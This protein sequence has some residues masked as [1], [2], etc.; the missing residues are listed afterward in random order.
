MNI[1]ISRKLIIGVFVSLYTNLPISR[2][3]FLPTYSS[4]VIHYSGTTG[5][6]LSIFLR[7]PPCMNIKKVVKYLHYDYKTRLIK[8]VRNKNLN[9]KTSTTLICMFVRVES[10]V[11]S[12]FVYLLNT[13]CHGS[14]PGVCPNSRKGR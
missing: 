13:C 7:F 6:F 11:P 8:K 12:Q 5:N 10:F 14:C 9:N 1:G 3:S 4:R 2:G